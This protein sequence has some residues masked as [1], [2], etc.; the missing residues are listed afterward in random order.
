MA[1]HGI[2][3]QHKQGLSNGMLGFI[4]FIAS[5]VMFFG[6]LFAA[7]FIARADATEWPPEN[8]LTAEQIARGVKLEV[9]FA[10]P[11]IAT[12]LLVLSSVTIQFGVWAIRRGDRTAL[13]RWLMVTIVLGLVFLTAQM[14][15]YSQLHFRA[16]DTVYGTTFYTLTGFHGAHVAGGVIFMG[17]ILA[18]SMA[19]QFSAA[20]HEAV[21]ACSFYWHFV[22]VVWIALFT[23]LYIVK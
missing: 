18:R 2:A 9:E 15:D 20:R 8:M 6:G 21:E 11:F 5:E 13:I 7:Y 10:L 23:V 3:T 22:D 17:V 12:I 4:L 16:G 1:T 14:F 19:G